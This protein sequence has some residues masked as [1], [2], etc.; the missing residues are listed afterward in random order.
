MSRFAQI[1]IER[2]QWTRLRLLDLYGRGELSARS[3]HLLPRCPPVSCARR[4]R[5]T[6]DT[7][8]LEL[9][10]ASG[11]RASPTRPASS[12]C[13]MPSAWAKC[14]SRSPAIPRAGDGSSDGAGGGCGHGGRLHLAPGEHARR[15]WT[16]RHRLAGGR[17]AGSD[18]SSLR[19][20]SASRRF[21]PCSTP[22][23]RPRGDYGPVSAPLRRAHPGRPALPARARALAWPARPR[24]R[25][26]RRHRRRRLARD[27]WAW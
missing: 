25:R 21:G 13:S 17:R 5:E 9:E 4:R 3:A 11:Q 22:A 2:L 15:P 1:L 20:A 23:R 12:R 10:P 6:A 26:H 14:R 18:V 19:A 8:T 27:R 7:W 16:V 24:R